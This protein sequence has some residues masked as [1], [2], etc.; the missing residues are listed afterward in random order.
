VIGGVAGAAT[1]ALVSKNKG[2]GALIGAGVGTG[3]GYLY[4]RRK[5]KK[6]VIK[7]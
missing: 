5:D 3:A 2:R 1:G 7:N 6:A 4:G